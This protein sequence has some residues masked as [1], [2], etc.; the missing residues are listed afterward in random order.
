MTVSKNAIVYGG[1]GAIGS[2]VASAFATEGARV[3]LAGRTLDKLETAAEV[4]RSS[5]RWM[6]KA[7]DADADGVARD[8]ASIDI[9]FNLWFGWVCWPRK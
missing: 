7:L 1:G 6:I 2:A 9:S 8:A 4:I 5:M 3:C